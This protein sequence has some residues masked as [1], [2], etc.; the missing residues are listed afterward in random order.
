MTIE[1]KAY[2]YAHESMAWCE[3]Y[4]FTYEIAEYKIEQAYIAGA[5]ENGTVWHDLRKDPSD[6]PKDR[7]NV[8]ITYINAYY[9]T[10]TTEASF[11]HKFW[12]IGGHKT[13]C[14]VIAWCEIPRFEGV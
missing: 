10:E 12:V 11:R 5:K 14:E 4:D 6:L 13:E 3:D 8:W 2:E 1:E 7:S 9:Q